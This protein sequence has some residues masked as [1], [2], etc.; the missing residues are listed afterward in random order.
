MDLQQWIAQDHA[1]VLGRF[2][3]AIGQHVPVERWKG[4]SPTHDGGVD[5]ASAHDGVSPTLAWLLF[6]ITVHQDLA[7]NTAIRNQPPLIARHRDDLGIDHLPPWSGLTEAEDPEVTSALDLDRLV[8]YVRAVN[9]RTS[10]WIGQLSVMALDS[11]P[12]N[13]YRLATLADIPADGAMS[14][15]HSMWDRKPVSWLVQWECIGHG[16]AHVGEMVGIRNRLG[17]SPF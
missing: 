14:W 4:G 6:H 16:H 5:G 3:S 15:L 11:V 13:S 1:F 17:L 8:D 9:A 12:A 10:D 2:D 7:I